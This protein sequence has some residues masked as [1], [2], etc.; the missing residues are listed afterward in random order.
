[1]FSI[2]A[3]GIVAV[4][5]LRVGRT[6]V[7]GHHVMHV[8]LDTGAILNISAGHP[9]AD[10]RPFGELVAGEALDPLHTVKRAELISYRFDAT[11]DILPASDTGTY[12]AAGASIGSSLFRSGA[13]PK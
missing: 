10:G 1:V 4:P 6:P 8:E 5:I 3:D 11:Y 9:T 13:L 7:L 2:N 12:F